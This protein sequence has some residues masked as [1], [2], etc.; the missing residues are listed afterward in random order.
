MLGERHGLGRHQNGQEQ[1]GFPNKGVIIGDNI[2]AGL[3]GQGMCPGTS[4]FKGGDH[5]KPVSA[6]KGTNGV[7]HV[8]RRHDSNGR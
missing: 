2:D 4:P 6:Q 7:P 8:T 3:R 1:I 5:A